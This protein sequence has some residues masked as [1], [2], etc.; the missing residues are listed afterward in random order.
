MG[1]W[2]MKAGWRTRWHSRVLQEPC[3]SLTDGLPACY[4]YLLR[5]PAC[6]KSWVMKRLRRVSEL[7]RNASS[8]GNIL[9][10]EEEELQNCSLAKTQGTAVLQEQNWR[11]CSTV[12]ADR[13]VHQQRGIGVKN[14]RGKHM[15]E[16]EIKASGQALF[17]GTHWAET[18]EKKK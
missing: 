16:N 6:S 1:H 5:L 3:G 8:P 18:T 10:R 2:N 13:A 7:K 4:N 14:K 17:E 12:S 11:S 9:G 15:S